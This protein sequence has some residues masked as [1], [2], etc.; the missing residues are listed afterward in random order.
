[1][2]ASVPAEATRRRYK[3]LLARFAAQ[4]VPV[5][6]RGFRGPFEEPGCDVAQIFE[7]S[8][9]KGDSKA[10]LFEWASQYMD[11]DGLSNIVVPVMRF[12]GDGRADIHY[13][14]LLGDPSD[15]AKLARENPTK[16]PGHFPFKV[17]GIVLEAE[18]QSWREQRAHLSSAFLPGQQLKPLL[19]TLQRGVSELLD[20]WAGLQGPLEA[21]DE[22]HH[23]ALDF[24]LQAMIGAK[25]LLPPTP[26][27]SLAIREAFNLDGVNLE[28]L[29]RTEA[30]R[31]EFALRVLRCG[32]TPPGPLLERLLSI[33]DDEKRVSSVK[34]FLT[35]GHDTTAHTLEWVLLELAR[36]PEVQEACRMEAES[37]F[38]E[39]G[40]RSLCYEDLLRFEVTSAVIFETLRLWGPAWTVFRR[41]LTA[42]RSF[43]GRVGG[44]T[45]PQ[46]T[47]V[48]FWFY[49]HHHSAK[50]WGPDA[51]EFRPLS[52]DFSDA[53]LQRGTS[54]TPSSERFHPFSLPGRDCM[55]KNFSLMEMR[56]LLP[57]MLCRFR[58]QLA[59]PWR[60][61]LEGLKCGSG[62]LFHGLIQKPGPA[63]PPKG[64][65]FE[66]EPLHLASQ[67]P[68]ARE[69]TAMERSR[70]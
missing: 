13:G 11:G 20:R 21:H 58:V 55:G 6:V 52:R 43:G 42:D 44:V 39:L 70:L 38:G 25:G 5:W 30:T 4:P 48:N 60:Q 47:A 2:A 16:D 7:A 9:A 62:D 68:S 12:D 69:L 53:E 14:L 1:M 51:C 27:E 10:S 54:R 65:C 67:L 35:A 64:L 32:A 3:K 28:D 56:L 26:R 57:Q 29:P 34:D 22:L 41:E 24:F 31:L 50:L 63:K 33:D 46:G 49:G 15:A 18:E 19:P 8:V 45:V 37:I 59:E 66:L 36:H 61:Q 40:G 23:A 17:Q